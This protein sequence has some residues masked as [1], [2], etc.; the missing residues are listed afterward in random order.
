MLT[1]EIFVYQVEVLNVGIGMLFNLCRVLVHTIIKMAENSKMIGKGLFTNEDGS[2]MVFFNTA[3]VNYVFS[4]YNKFKN[5]F[6]VSALQ[7]QT[8]PSHFND[9]SHQ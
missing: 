8:N 9:R 1:V 7:N 3:F 2:P 5:T 6:C 4:S